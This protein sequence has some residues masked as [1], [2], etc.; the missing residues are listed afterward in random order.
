MKRSLS[1]TQKVTSIILVSLVLGI[2]VVVFYFAYG[3]NKT[4]SDSTEENLHQQT[5]ILHESIKN[6]MLPG[7]APLAVSL[8]RDIR[9]SRAMY[10]IMLYRRNG[11]EAF[12]DNSTI[13][14][15]NTNLEMPRFQPHDL[16]VP[17]EPISEENDLF[18]QAVNTIT[19]VAS[20]STENEN[21]YFTIYKPLLNLPKCIGCH[22]S[23]HT[24]RGVIEI[25]ANLTSTL[26]E[27]RQNILIAGLIFV[28]VVLILFL[29]LSSFLRRTVIAPIHRIGHVASEVT[30]GNFHD[31]VFITTRDEIGRLAEQINTMVDGLYE[32]FELSKY[33]SSSTIQ[34]I[35]NSEKGTKTE[36]ALLF[37]DIRGFT[38]F[39][40]KVSPEAVVE[41]LNAI[42]A[43]QTDIIHRHGGDI[44]KYVGDEIVALF[45]GA[46]KERDA[47]IS[48]LEIQ[49]YI[50]FHAD[51]LAH[52]AV[53]IGINTG[54][55]V[56]GR[57]GSDVR[58]DFTVIGDHVNFASRLC[59]EAKRDM[60]LVS[61][62]TY[63]PLREL[64]E[65]KGPYEIRVKGKAQ[66]QH[67]YVFTNLKRQQAEQA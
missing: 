64:A 29:V 58:A 34:S 26:T 31:K 8:F 66:P 16:D 6:L 25:R 39:S 53:G 11:V 35:K 52:L 22:G 30:K 51:E 37:S 57:V 43:V 50:A 42:L 1:I 56:L 48:A 14:M 67:V 12:S 15:V 7:E 2:G 40:E 19:T 5:D 61:E 17:G 63:Q 46:Q 24:I 62:S 59:S 20:R 32:R 18:F 49:E 38:S 13:E 47:C 10:E 41:N 65:V 60:I 44:D 27:A 54:E 9:T 28:G 21:T 4:L 45:T 33:V 3:Q 36:M 23:D 55:V